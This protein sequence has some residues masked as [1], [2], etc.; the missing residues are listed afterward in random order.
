M[1]LETGVV[2]ASRALDKIISLLV[3]MT[4]LVSM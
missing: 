1:D 4:K 3:I 2:S